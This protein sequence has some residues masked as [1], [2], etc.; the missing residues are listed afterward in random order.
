MKVGVILQA[1]EISKHFVGVQALDRVQFELKR[2]EVHALVGENGAGKST[3]IKIIAGIY[4]RD[5]GRIVF[6]DREVEFKNNIE[7]RLSGIGM[8]PQEIQLVPKLSVAENIFMGLYPRT[9]YGFVRW[10]ELYRRAYDI[11][12]TFNIENLI[13]LHAEKL[14]TG[15]RQLIEI[16]KALVFNAK[17]IAFDEPTAALSEEETKELFELIAKLKNDGISIIYVSHRLDEIF[18]IADR[19]TVYKD[20][21]FVGTH[22]IKDVT[23]DMVVSMMVGREL[24]LYG[25]DNRTKG[26]TDKVVFE[27]RGLKRE[28]SI[29]DVSF[30]LCRGEILGLFGMVGS[31]RT[32][33]MMSVFG[34]DPLDEGEIF[35]AGEKV[36]IKSPIDAVKLGIGLV[37]EN[38]IK[39]GVILRASVRNNVTLP[40]VRKLTKYGAI[41][42]K[43]ELDIVRKYMDYL[44]IKARSESDLVNTLSGGNQQKV[45]IAKWLASKS[46]IIIFDEPTHGIDVGAKAEIYQL[47]R[48]LSDEGKSIIMISSELTEVLNVCD[49]ILVFRDG[50]IAHEFKENRDLTEEEVVQYALG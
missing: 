42:A 16:L 29:N 32:E 10:K 38:R 2:G 21:M 7:A 27:V 35:I 5:G 45:A 28:N 33:T 8:V 13:G 37:P 43:K 49:R 26:R 36:S 50:R 39:Q 1:S 11:A 47:L 44:N 30:Q 23:K 24:N 31:G 14:G 9:K 48:E 19:V 46:D 41:N 25:E 17:I 4:L 40:F 34:V 3:L 22:K 20:G 12:K 18:Q 15:Y 6:E